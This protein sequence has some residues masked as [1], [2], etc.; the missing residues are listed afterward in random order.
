[1]RIIVDAFGGDHAPL[2]VIKGCQMVVEEKNINIVLVG[3]EDTIKK[4]A[5][6]NN[7]SLEN[8]EIADAPDIISMNDA[9]SEIMKSKSNSSMAIGLKLLAEGKGDAFVTAGN[10]GAVVVG[11][12]FMIKRIKGIKRPAFSPVMPNM[13]TNFML[14][15]SGANIE[16]RPEML[17][18]FGIM[19]S[20]YMERVMKTK[21]PRVALLNVGTEEHKGG[22]VQHEAFKLLQNSNINFIGNVEGRDIPFDAADVVVADGFTGNVFLKTYEGTAMAI[23]NRFKAVLNKNLKTK[24]AAGLIMSDLKE[25]KKTIDYNE[26]GGAPIMGVC[27][28]VFKAHGSS[29]AKTIRNAILQTAS[30][31]EGDV[32]GE[33]TKEIEFLHNK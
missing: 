20:I 3:R 4:A 6:E 16:C 26:Y 33:I 32:I 10:S 1:M 7:I 18:Q 13:A 12:T 14:I 17:Q 28:P 5:D 22:D 29:K 23:L 21:N 9:G 27:K 30:Y 31:V 25:L 19:G 2:E 8:M 24:I 15:D 11:S